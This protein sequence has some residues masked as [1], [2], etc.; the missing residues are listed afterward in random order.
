M[1]SY[2]ADTIAVMYLGRIVEYGSVDDVLNNPAHPYTKALI[3]S[4]PQWDKTLEKKV[5]KLQ[6]NMPSPA[7]PPKGCHFHPR[8]PEVM[9]D[10]GQ[11]IPDK[12]DLSGTHSVACLLFKNA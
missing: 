3:A 5:I 10:C 9:A 8:C 7:N 1:V 11:K 4:V 2:L 12:V 6:D